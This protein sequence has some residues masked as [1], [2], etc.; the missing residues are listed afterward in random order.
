MI[1]GKAMSKFFPAI[2]TPWFPIG[3]YEDS[4][5]LVTQ[6]HTDDADWAAGGAVARLA[7]AGARVVY[8]VA[9]KGEAGSNEPGMTKEKLT[10]IRQQE[11]RDANAILGVQETIF[12]GHE[13]GRLNRVKD[14]D[15]QIIALVRE[16]KPELILTFDVDR[17]E[18][19]MHPDHRAI[20]LATLRAAQFSG[21]SLTYT[22]TEAEPFTCKEVLLYDPPAPNSFVPVQQYSFEKL[23]ALA[24]HKS[25]MV[26]LLP[27][28]LHKIM[29]DIV[30]RG[31][32]LDTRLIARALHYSFLVEPFRR[33][34]QHALLR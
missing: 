16:H 26:H 29:Y 6:A 27:D 12:L 23:Q 2:V 10:E 8:V 19:F 7:A 30:E 4:T 33:I 21:L 32:R 24:A 17:P 1:G 28:W 14:L 18:Y 22:D 15:E 3:K 25:Q 5:V 11:Q 34:P 13:D 31:N 9:T 20:G